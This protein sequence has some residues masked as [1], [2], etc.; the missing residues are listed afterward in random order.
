M[1]FLER[2]LAIECR[3][4]GEALAKIIDWLEAR[5]DELDAEN[6]PLCRS[7]RRSLKR[8][9]VLAAA[10][11]Q[12]ASI[13]FVGT[14]G[15]GKSSLIAAVAT[16]APAGIARL[17]V[18]LDQTI[19]PVD[20]LTMLA[21]GTAVPGT[22][23]DRSSGVGLAVRYLVKSTA[24]PPGFP[25]T[26]ELMSQLDV[27]KV[28][29][30][31]YFS[32]CPLKSD[33]VPEAEQVRVMALEAGQHMSLFQM[34]GLGEDDIA[35]LRDDI[36]RRYHDE[37]LVKA[38]TASGYWEYCRAIISHLPEGAR[39][40]LLSVL[41]GGS[42]TL[43][44]IYLKA[45]GALETLAH[46]SEIHCP[47]EALV[48]PEGMAGP[49]A[50]HPASIAF[51]ETLHRGDHR[52]APLGVRTKL[53]QFASIERSVLAL[54]V[55]ELR[56]TLAE[57]RSLAADLA[58]L[59]E[60]PT[61]AP[62]PFGVPSGARLDQ[63]TAIALFAREKS[64]YLLER[65]TDRSDLNALVV[66]LD[67]SGRDP[68]TL[69]AAV[70]DWVEAM[71]GDEP[72]EREASETAL[73]IAATK[74]NLSVPVTAAADGRS[75]VLDGIG[76][77]LVATLGRSHRWPLEWTSG[78]AF[79]NVFLIRHARAGDDG[80]APA[81]QRV[82]NALVARASAGLPALTTGMR[83]V[84]AHPIAE[85]HFQDIVKAVAEA[86]DPADGGIS[87]LSDSIA[88]VLQSGLR[89]RQLAQ[90]L[91]RLKLHLRDVLLRKYP[92]ADPQRQRLWR[93]RDQRVA[94]ARL[95]QAARSQ[96]FGH[97]MRELQVSEVELAE[98]FQ[99]IETSTR[100]GKP[101]SEATKAE[102]SPGGLVRLYA[103]AAVGYWLD[104]VRLL[105]EAKA[106]QRRIG[107]PGPVLTQIVEEMAAGAR[108]MGLVGQLATRLSW[109]SSD[110]MTVEE[111]VARSAVHA[112]H[113]IAGFVATLGYD[114]QRAE[115]HPRR[116]GRNREP[117]FSGRHNGEAGSPLSAYAR[118]GEGGDDW[119]VA[120]AGMVRS[121][122][123]GQGGR[124]DAE[125][126]RQISELLSVLG[127]T[128]LEYEP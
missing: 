7:L 128:G 8:I 77:M 113:V 92:G 75:S 83:E 12:P 43:T 37:P 108:A 56:L 26:F 85:R 121:S 51:T 29:A 84:A 66:C 53:G 96:R 58:A 28:L 62:R 119:Q 47:L 61:P 105:S 19:P 35:A 115:G 54:L 125:H 102:K 9:D 93:L 60:M 1:S 33:L 40:A 106:L 109:M 31:A 111:R 55:A 44:T 30:R 17:S 89:Q 124:G 57:P 52:E 23:A 48:A 76:R 34:R 63:Q 69:S 67:P 49:S 81:G 117:I 18:A 16:G 4:S 21:G 68:D 110:R 13:G 25:L 71:H 59:V 36:E 5:S 65:A 27:V 78:Q 118:V 2:R 94:L 74:V 32:N 126:E 91:R 14:A 114:D 72:A 46:A 11:L 95:K 39:A 24:G 20:A 104:H 116:V 122:V 15:S 70:G 42:P 82:R 22:R 50:P 101:G 112:A 90:S 127:V 64:A 6:G 98:V 38:L 88:E 87:Y 123:A 45:A 73:F 86:E 79:D 99:H 97:L 10:A 41:W 80:A 103:A 120:Y 3:Q 100:D 107:I